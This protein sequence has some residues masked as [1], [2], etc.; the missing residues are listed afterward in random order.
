MIRPLLFLCLMTIIS[1]QLVS[2]TRFTNVT[3]DAGIDHTFDI[4]EGTF[5]GG[6][7][8]ID[9]NQDGWEDIFLAG[10]QGKDQL[11]QNQGDG[12]FI[13]VSEE[14]GLGVLDGYV[15]QGAAVADVNKDGWPDL[16]ITTIAFV[17]GDGFA[18]A[19]NVLLIN[20]EG[21]FVDE[22]S[23]FGLLESTFSTGASFGDVNSDG[24][25]DLYVCNYFDNYQGSLD[26]FNG[27]LQ[28]GDIQPGTDL[29]YINN[30]GQGFV[31][32]STDFGISGMGLTFQALWSDF[33]NDRD[34][35]LL[36]VNDFGYR[37][38]PNLLY[39]N[40]Y[41]RNEF[42]EV[43]SEKNFNYGINGMGISSC[44]V[45]EDG[46][47]DYK[48]TNIGISPFLINNGKDAPFTEESEI[49]GTAFSSVR[50]NGGYWVS[51]YSWGINFFDVDNDMDSDLY[52]TNGALNPE[53]APNPNLLLENEN[54]NFSDI[55]FISRT[56]DHSIGRG[57]IVFDYD[58]DGDLD[59]LVINQMPFSNEDVGVDFH[60]TRLYRNDNDNLNN[61][62]KVKLIGEQSESSGIGSR[63]EIHTNDRLLIREIYGGSSHE[64]Q[65]TTIAHFG[66]GTINQIDSLVIK[67]NRGHTQ[68]LLDVE[69]NQTLEVREEIKDQL[70][71]YNQEHLIVYPN[72]FRDEVAISYQLPVPSQIRMNVFDTQG[73]LVKQLIPSKEG[74][75]GTYTWQVP[76]EIPAGLYLFVLETD[77]GIHVAKGIKK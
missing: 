17:L 39:R 70:S 12:T 69:A 52:I 66:L 33:D 37:G 15:T 63:V 45:N 47:L 56:N 67:W 1:I 4:F 10:G 75:W 7:A 20:H 41:P 74:F 29:F 51:P 71:S 16:F 22:S 18:K 43:G 61:W 44:D 76:E 42:T 57:S 19:P 68:I 40:E 53:M 34:L 31:E 35:D 32:A 28:N 48:I 77:S 5:G 6:A 64:S 73:S 59:L 23:S 9:F 27:P 55:G 14:Y 36:I 62:L 13:D 24:Y 25:P 26:A 2:Q 50:V 30:R 21:T 60:G 3:E 54:G 38:T 11:L 58:H 46:W 72:A 8:V 49:R 65:N